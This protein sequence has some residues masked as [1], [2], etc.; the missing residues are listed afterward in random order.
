MK[1]LFGSFDLLASR[2]WGCKTQ[3]WDQNII[4]IEEGDVVVEKILVI[5]SGKG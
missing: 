5:L 1:R 4:W 3:L 2:L